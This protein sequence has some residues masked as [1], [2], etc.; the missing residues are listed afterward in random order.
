[1][2]KD[3]GELGWRIYGLQYPCTDRVEIHRQRLLTV[4]TRVWKVLILLTWQIRLSMTLHVSKRAIAKL[5]SLCSGMLL[6]VAHM[7]GRMLEIVPTHAVCTHLVV[8]RLVGAVAAV[9]RSGSHIDLL[10][11]CADVTISQQD[12]LSLYQRDTKLT[13]K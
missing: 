10:R 9:G 12:I 5:G 11:V 2:Q 6:L 8:T 13:S 1:M 4:S 3:Q 7:L